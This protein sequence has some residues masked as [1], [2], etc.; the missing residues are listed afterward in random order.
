MSRQAERDRQKRETE[1]DAGVDGDE[2]VDENVVLLV[3][4]GAKA[5]LCTSLQ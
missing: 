1:R 4:H 3:D 2:D 5:S